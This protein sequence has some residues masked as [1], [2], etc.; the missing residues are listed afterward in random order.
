MLEKQRIRTYSR[1][2][3]KPDLACAFRR[4]RLARTPSTAKT[5]CPSTLAKAAAALTATATDTMPNDASFLR[6]F[7]L[8]VLAV[9]H[10]PEDTHQKNRCNTDC[11]NNDDL[12]YHDFTV[13]L[14]KVTV[15]A[16]APQEEE[17]RFGQKRFTRISILRLRAA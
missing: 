3:R 5:G 7:L 9:R 11:D 10:L 14:F 8:A 1:I 2:S 17:M 15:T 4:V 16:T 12:C 6:A 13:S